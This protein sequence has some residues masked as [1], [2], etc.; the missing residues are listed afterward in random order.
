MSTSQFHEINPDL[1]RPSVCIPEFDIQF[2]HFLPRD[3]QPLLFHPGSK[4][5]FPALREGV[6]KLIDPTR[7][8]HIAWS[9]LE[10][11]Q[12]GGLTIGRSPSG[13]A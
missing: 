2:K 6:A 12:C 13:R 7:L 8:P 10:S 3:G 5:T 1:G 9:H 4:A 11:N